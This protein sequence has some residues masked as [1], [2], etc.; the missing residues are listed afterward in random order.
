MAFL[1]GWIFTLLGVIFFFA[2]GGWSVVRALI[3]GRLGSTP[4]AVQIV[5]AELGFGL[6]LLGM[7]LVTVGMIGAR[8][9]QALEE[10]EREQ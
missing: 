7:I 2:G 3:E 6:W 5:F 9:R 4:L 10:K 1:F 8:K